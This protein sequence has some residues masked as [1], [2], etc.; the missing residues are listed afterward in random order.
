VNQALS[1][2][3]RRVVTVVAGVAAAALALVPALPTAATAGAASGTYLAAAEYFGSGNPTNMWSS[4][5]SGAPKAFALMKHEGFNT[6]GLILPWGQFQPGLT[7]PSYDS[8]T[9]ARLDQ[10]ITQATHLHMGVILRLS[11]EWDVDPTDQLPGATRF[12]Q[13]WSN[14]KVYAAWLDYVTTVHQNVA[15]FHNVRAAY[16][17]WE[18]LW[19][20]VFEAQGTTT[21]GQQLSLATSSGYRPWLEKHYTLPQAEFDYGTQFANW[22]A[23]PVPSATKPS[24]KLMYQYEDTALV[25]RLFDPAAKRFPGLTMESRADVD[26]VLT[27]TTV[28]GSYTHHAQY[29]LPGTSVTGMYFSPYMDDPSQT[30]VESATDALKA[31]HSTLSR[32]SKSTG[33]RP[34]VI[35]EYEFESNANAVDHDPA[36]TPN[37]IP[38]FLAGSKSQLQRYTHGYALWTF[39][40]YYLSAI[41]NPSFALGST[42][43]KLTGAQAVVSSSAPSYALFG[44]EGGSVTQDLPSADI[45]SAKPAS[46][47]FRAD[48]PAATNVLVRLGSS[49]GQTVPIT[50]GWHT[51]TV[52]LSPTSTGSVTLQAGGGT[53]LTNV[54]VYWFTQLGDVYSTAGS[55]EV[56]VAP[57]RSLNARLTGSG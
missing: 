10:L 14:P 23:V 34:L 26:S 4:D 28:V 33:G 36:L 57:L 55:P 44:P 12:A 5:L 20:P 30:M 29:R 16:I 50:P 32:M 27:G 35:Y 37:Q 13:L 42:G 18:D 22:T 3:F 11:Y 46:V 51:Y 19:E 8:T 40:D 17:S 6:V 24:F 38:R 41:Y 39:H 53:M 9:F 43:W 31:M 25:H 15:Q 47:S 1:P 2:A 21:P 56:G 7:P 48:A 45:T 52:T 49:P 54:A